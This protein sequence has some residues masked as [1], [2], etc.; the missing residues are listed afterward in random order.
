MPN[1]AANLTFLWTE[2]PFL[3]RFEAAARAGFRG[4][5]FHYPYAYDAQEIKS[6]LAQFRLAP[7]LHNISAGDP[8]KGDFGLACLPDRVAEFRAAVAQAIDYALRIGTPKCNCLA[9][10]VPAGVDV[11]ASEATLIDNLKFAGREFAKAGLVLTVEPLN[12]INVPGFLLTTSAHTMAILDQVA[13][14]NVMLQY[15]LYH[16]QIMEGDLVNTMRR[17]QPRIGHIQFADSPGRHE[18][19]TGAIDFT[20]AFAAIDA[21]GYSGWVAAEYRPSVTTAHS[22]AWFTA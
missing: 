3:D 20:E 15:D 21:M 1:F 19:G 22:L 7:V 16:M 2:R 4:V 6:R 14:P 13:L 18:P 5:E 12:N 8:D 17:L 10:K 11:R 9:G